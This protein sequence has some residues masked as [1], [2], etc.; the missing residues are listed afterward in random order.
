MFHLSDVACEHMDA[1]CD[2]RLASHEL[3]QIA[4]YD[5]FGGEGFDEEYDED[6]FED[7]EDFFNS[8]ELPQGN[9]KKRKGVALAR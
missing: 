8:L 7:D 3:S 6:G 2:D 4:S 1:G 5:E 9:I